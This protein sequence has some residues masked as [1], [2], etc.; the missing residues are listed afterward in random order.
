[1]ERVT[2]IGGVFFRAK[3]PEGL[4]SWYDRHLGILPSPGDFESPC[5]QQGA[6]PT[7]FAP[8]PSDTEYLGD[9]SKSWMINLRVENLESMIAQF[10]GAGIEVALDPV[11]YPNGRF[12]R[13]KDPEGNPIELWQP[14][15]RDAPRAH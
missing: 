3:D 12:A 15:S 13:L 9:P 2:G 6:G 4:G 14:Q 7:V 5:W 11:E 8:F 1:M 10:R